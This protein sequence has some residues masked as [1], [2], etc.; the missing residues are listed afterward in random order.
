M[1]T[2]SRGQRRQVLPSRWKVRIV[3]QH[4]AL[5][6]L[7]H[8][9][10]DT[11]CD[12]SRDSGPSACFRSQH[13]AADGS[14]DDLGDVLSNAVDACSIGATVAAASTR[15]HQNAEYLHVQ[16]RACRSSAN[17][18][19]LKFTQLT[20][21]CLQTNLTCCA[22][23]AGVFHYVR[24]EYQAKPSACHTCCL[25]AVGCVLRFYCYAYSALQ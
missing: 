25:R 18:T 11:V 14:D 13:F 9:L 5:V 4:S 2:M 15:T 22:V 21:L 20:S 8:R 12:I 6:G 19:Q 23:A 17:Q 10:W 16:H 24:C 1:C 7:G 3:R